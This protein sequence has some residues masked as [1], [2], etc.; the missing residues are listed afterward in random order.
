MSARS[1][2]PARARAPACT[3]SARPSDVRLGALI[4]ATVAAG[5]GLPDGDY[6][7]RMPDRIEPG[8]LRF[9][10]SGEP[11]GLDPAATSS[12]TAMKPV[13]LLFDGLTDFDA[14]GFP[15]PSLA[16]HWD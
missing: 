2:A 10:N 7:G 5:C 11:E 13:Y 6:F 4:A 15:E 16:T 12:T 1:S 9:C 3:C 14:Q 8:H